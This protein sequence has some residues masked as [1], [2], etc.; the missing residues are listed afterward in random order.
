MAAAVAA[1][2]GGHLLIEDVPGVGKTV[3]ARTLAASLGAELSRVQG[4]PDLLPSD[5]TGVS[6]FMP[7]TG[8]WDFR[9]GPVFAARRAGGRAEP[10]AAAHAVGA[11]RDDGGAAGQRRRPVLAAAPTRTW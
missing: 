1:L 5:I 3:L 4:H 6:V 11:P 9:P 10:H 8:S 7:D 2:S